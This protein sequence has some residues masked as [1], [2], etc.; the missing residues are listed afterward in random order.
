MKLTMNFEVH[1]Y[2]TLLHVSCLALFYLC[3]QYENYYYSSPVNILSKE[4]YNIRLFVK[5][6]AVECIF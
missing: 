6:L 5:D 3:C 1:F 2:A 4:F